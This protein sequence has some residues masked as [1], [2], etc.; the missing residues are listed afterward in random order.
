MNCRKFTTP[1]LL[2]LPLLACAPAMAAYT[3][4]VS[5][6]SVS[7][8]YS[9]TAPSDNISTGLWIMNCTR[10]GGDASNLSYS[11]SADN[12]VQPAGGFNRVR[13]GAT[14]N[15]Y[16]YAAY[17]SAPYVAGNRWQA[18]GPFVGTLSFG[19]SL[20]G[21]AFGTF[22]VVV[23]AGQAVKP[24]GTYTDIVTVTTRNTGTAATLDTSNFNV[25]VLT[26]N[27]C[28]I[29]TPP[30][31][32]NFTYTSFQNTA[33]T[34]GTTFASRCTTGLP[35]TMALDATSGNLLGLTYT[36]SLPVAAATG[37]GVDQTFNIDGSIAAS[38]SGV[39]TTATCVDTQSRTLTISY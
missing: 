39:C 8:V 31:N 3:C 37:T 19:G 7:P 2:L 36:L 25:S 34:S 18:T 30:G 9:P 17:R 27:T 14:A 4:T 5:V 24:A 16:D 13:N 1:L 35:Y 15:F 21:S 38:Q 12:G 29:T 28:Q 32:I 23:P 26:S 10:A 11:I 6:T 20:T 22:D 33:A